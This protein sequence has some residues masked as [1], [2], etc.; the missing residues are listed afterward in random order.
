MKD[1]LIQLSL[2]QDLN[3]IISEIERLILN[4]VKSDLI[5]WRTALR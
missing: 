2:S 1:S 5:C 4:C 3:L